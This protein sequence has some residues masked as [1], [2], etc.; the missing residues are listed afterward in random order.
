M[1]TKRIWWEIH[2]EEDETDIWYEVRVMDDQ[3]SC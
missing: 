2:V 3:Q 1:D